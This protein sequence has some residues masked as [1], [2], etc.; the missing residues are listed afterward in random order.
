MHKLKSVELKLKNNNR[1]VILTANPQTEKE[2]FMLISSAFSFMNE[3]I[4][5]SLITA[6]YL[7]VERL[8]TSFAE[9]FDM[10]DITE[11][12]EAIK[13]KTQREEDMKVIV[14]QCPDGIKVKNG[15]PHYRTKYKC[16]CGYRGTHYIPSVMSK[17]RCHSCGYQMKVTYTNENST[18]DNILPNEYYVYFESL[19][20]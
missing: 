14:N 7:K 15:K 1:E 12:N 3:D 20:N 6:N 17:I 11:E 9:Q 4:P 13:I 16:K 18:S 19:I 8:Y 5:D 10:R 2:M